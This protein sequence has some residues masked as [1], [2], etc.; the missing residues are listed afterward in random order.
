MRMARVGYGSAKAPVVNTRPQS[1]SIH[2]EY[3]PLVSRNDPNVVG[4]GEPPATKFDRQNPLHQASDVLAA[5]VQAIRLAV[6]AGPRR[7]AK[8][9]SFHRAMCHQVAPAGNVR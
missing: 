4:R 5:E 6:I 7:L 8:F 1:N 9:W 3:M 2:R